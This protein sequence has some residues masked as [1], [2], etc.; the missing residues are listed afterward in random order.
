[1]LDSRR[2]R[3]SGRQG[4]AR[5]PAIAAEHMVATSQGAATRAGLRALD[6]GGTAADAA[7]AAAAALCAAVRPLGQPPS[8]RVTSSHL[9]KR[10]YS[11]YDVEGAV[12]AALSA[13]LADARA[14]R[15]SGKL[16]TPFL[17]QAV[18]RATEGDCR[19]ANVRLL[20]E[21]ARVAGQ[22]AVALAG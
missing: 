11:R 19:A 3:S 1:M 7:I 10:N 2:M 14:R 17:L 22:V 18:D 9:G 13:A 5:P 21:N 8:Y 20:E 4:R 16:L 6:R 12:E 15:L